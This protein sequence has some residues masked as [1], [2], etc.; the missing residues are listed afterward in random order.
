MQEIVFPQILENP[1]TVE[2]ERG[3][4]FRLGFRWVSS[5]GVPLVSETNLY[6]LAYPFGDRQF[7]IPSD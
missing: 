3:T 6:L 1:F 7:M 4:H 5:D 2:D